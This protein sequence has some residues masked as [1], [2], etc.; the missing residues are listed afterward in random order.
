MTYS[1]VNDAPVV[2]S[3]IADA[4]TAEDSAYSLNVAGTCT[5]VDGDTLTYSISGAPSTITISGTTISGTPVNANVGTHTITVTCTDDGSGTLSASDQYVLTVTNVN[6]A[7]TITSNA[8]TA[9]NEDAAYSYTVTTNDVDG[10][11]VSLTGTT[12]PSWMSFNTN[13]GAL[14]GTPTNSHVGSHSVVITASDGNSGSV[15]D[16]FTVVVSNV[17]DAPTVTSA[18]ADASTAEDAAYLSLIHI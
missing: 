13:T 8:V 10:D 14:T 5:D 4:S 9:V 15:T 12:V 7:P 11:T 18:I 1:A 2:A 6:D 16:T 17:N 3:A